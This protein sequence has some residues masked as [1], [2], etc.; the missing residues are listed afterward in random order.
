MLLTQELFKSEYGMFKNYSESRLIWFLDLSFEDKGKFQLVGTLVGLAV[1]N[2]QIINLPFPL[3]LFKKILNVPLNLNGLCELSPTIGNSMKSLLD[4]ED[5]DMEDVFDLT[6]EVTREIFDTWETVSL[7]DNGANIHVNQAN[8][9]VSL[10]VIQFLT[11][12][13]IRKEF[14]DLYIDYVLNKSVEKQYT[15]FFKGFMKVCHDSVLFLFQAHEL[16]DVII[17]NENYDWD[18][19]ENNTKYKRGYSSSDLTVC[20]YY[21]SAAEFQRS[22]HKF[23]YIDSRLNPIPFSFQ[24]RLFWK[25]FH[26]LPLEEKK[27]F[28]L[29]LTGCDRIPLEGMKAIQVS[30]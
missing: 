16:L 12:L 23:S 18:V 24:I 27:K 10:L 6:F 9:C 22:F 4:Y 17:G 28:L 8:K 13:C 7:K 25:V 29:F 1:Y 5:D 2:F 26:E 21:H 19:F 20:H 3:A 30:V 14:V 15:E 11:T